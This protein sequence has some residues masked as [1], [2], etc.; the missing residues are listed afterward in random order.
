MLFDASP[1][2]GQNKF[3]VCFIVF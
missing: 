3:F 1:L 2:K